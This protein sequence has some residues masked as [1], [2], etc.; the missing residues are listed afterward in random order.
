[1]STA[2]RFLSNTGWLV[3]DKVIRL[4]LGLLVG[5]LVARYLGPAKLG[6]ISYAYALLGLWGALAGL[7]LDE[8]V[9]KRLVSDP[10]RE[11][12][13][14]GTAV[15]LRT[16]AG[17]V[18]YGGCVAS[19]FALAGDDRLGALVTTVVSTALLVKGLEAVDSYFQSKLLSQYSFFSLNVAALMSAAG[20][21][22]VVLSGGGL[23]LLAAAFLLESLVAATLLL[24]MYT[25]AGGHVPTWRFSG[26]DARSLLRE[27][28]PL[29]TSSIMIVV[30]MRIDQVM[31]QHMVG[32]EA[33]GI[34]SVAT[35]L[36][37]AWYFLPMAFAASAY[38]VLVDAR[39]NRPESF[40]RLV[41]A[42]FFCLTWGGLIF[43]AAIALLSRTIV[44]FLYGTEFSAAA[45]LL[46]VLCWAGVFVAQGIGRG[47]WLLAMDLQVYSFWYVSIGC[48]LNVALNFLLIPRHGAMGAAVASLI[49][50]MVVALVAPALFAPT[51]VS[52]VLLAKSFLPAPSTLRNVRR[53][54]GRACGH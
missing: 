7:G 16:L 10:S 42:F 29:A 15:V 37:E 8:T 51:R 21:L 33:V 49:A 28:W 18:C 40:R 12:Q 52:A 43:G 9:V 53:L 11:A 32:S 19:S 22:A 24:V 3:L 26:A 23:L 31:L 38:P 45:P 41:D 36:A 39:N 34:Y 1:M 27:S 14:L 5:V 30:Y 44:Q 47:K 54:V 35:R 2:R 48:G 4:G 17:V 20:K 25:R 6:L 46:A 13:T 50:Q